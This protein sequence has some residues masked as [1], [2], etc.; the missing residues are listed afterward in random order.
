MIYLSREN[1]TKNMEKQEIKRQIIEKLF[2]EPLPDLSE[3]EKKYPPRELKEGE[4]VTRV[5]PSPTGYMHIGVLYTSLISERLAHQTG[6]VF[7]LRIEDTDKKREV[8]GSVALIIESLERYGIKVDEGEVSSGSEVGQYGPYRQSN[9][10]KIYMAYVKSLIEKGLAYPCFCTQEELE[11]MRAKQEKQS[12]RPGYYKQWAKWRDKSDEEVLCALEEG[13]KFV[14]RF[15]SMGDFDNKM[16]VKDVLKGERNLPENDQDIVIMKTEGLPTYHMAHVVD[17]HLMGTTHVIRGDEWLSSLTLH[18]QLFESMGWQPPEYGHMSPIQKMEGSSKRKISKRK[19]PEANMTFYDKQGYPQKA[20]VE[21]LMNLA[22]SSFEDWRKAN[23]DK[24]NREFILTF[25]RLSNSSGA[26]FDFDKLENISKEV[27]AGFSAEEV[28]KETFT[29][30]EKWDPDFAKLM[31]QNSDYAKK[32]LSIE[33]GKEGR[34]RKD[35]SKWS[36]VKQD[37]EYF[38]DQNFHLTKE[39]VNEKLSGIDREDLKKVIES[40]LKSYKKDDSSEVWF[41]KLK[42][43]ARSNG[44][45]DAIK[46]F[47]KNPEKYKGNIADVAKIFRVLLTGRLQSPDLYSIMQVMGEERITTRLRFFEKE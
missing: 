14:I 19:D 40:F 3:I 12:V 37:I 44:F 28:F 7:Y 22:N 38:F 11:E 30:A 5:A 42:E 45:A 16:I 10:A 24:D 23:P 47:K 43:V 1:L 29:W 18:L 25:G 41:E 21:Y 35:I 34:V 20:V 36:G 13:K 8:P 31:E 46:D 32:I 26:L 39:D 17:D 27:I 15:K 6:G 9:R 2:P 33:R 4:M